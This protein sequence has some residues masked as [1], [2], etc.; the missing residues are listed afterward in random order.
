MYYSQIGQ[1]IWVIE[2]LYPGKSSGYFVD[3]G[4]YDGIEFSNTYA[5]ENEHGWRG[6]CVEAD[7]LNFRKLSQNRGCVC[8]ESLVDAEPTKRKFLSTGSMMSRPFR[9]SARGIKERFEIYR[10][11]K[12]HLSKSL[13]KNQ[14]SKILTAQSRALAEILDEHHAPSR[15][16][17]LS[18]DI[19]GGELGILNRFP[20]DRYAFGAIT[21]E[22]KLTNAAEIKN[23][24]RF[25]SSQGYDL[26]R[27][28]FS[29][30]F[31]VN[32]DLSARDGDARAWFENQLARRL[33]PRFQ[34]KPELSH[35]P[36]IIEMHCGKNSPQAQVLAC[37]QEIF[38][39]MPENNE[40]L[41]HLGQH[42]NSGGDVE[43]TRKR[44]LQES[45]KAAHAF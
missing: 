1:D 43:S 12:R 45:G 24:V 11:R 35:I 25:M 20:Y 38:G 10:E 13:E 8:V 5:L 40:F 34:R 26:E 39:Q 18:L 28:F 21:A 17:Y 23:F 30:Y 3:V 33:Q 29:D 7:P 41:R 22:I 16:D 19:E 14:E 15:I 31:F 4:A 27:V 44:M 9:E 6:I 36:W 42:V 2:R 37:Y 32:R